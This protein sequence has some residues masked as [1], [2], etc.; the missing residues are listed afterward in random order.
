MATDQQQGIYYIKNTV[1]GKLYIGSSV[2]IQSRWHHHRSALRHGK[3]TNPKLTNGWNKYGESAFEFGVLEEVSQ[4]QDLIPRED[5]YILTLDPFY[6]CLL[7]SD[8]GRHIPTPESKAAMAASMK[9][10]K[11]TPEHRAK[12]SK[13]LKGHL[14]KAST[15]LKIGSARKQFRHTEKT[16]ARLA[17]VRLGWKHPENVKAKI[18]ASNQ[19]KHNHSATNN[20]RYDHTVYRFKHPDGRMFEGTRFDFYTKYNL[21][22]GMVSQVVRGLRASVKKWVLV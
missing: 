20:P 12:I 1:N 14:V 19:G 15:R 5:H 2:D 7:A 6:N 10:R 22:A 9:G 11:F 13:G 18:K 16:K 4:T 3:H 17:E 21:S 8:G